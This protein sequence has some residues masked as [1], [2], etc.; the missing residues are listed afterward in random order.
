MDSLF[1]SI[2]TCAA[3]ASP[4]E[5]TPQRLL[6]TEVPCRWIVK[7][8]CIK[9]VPL[10]GQVWLGTVGGM[11]AARY[12]R[13]IR[14]SAAPAPLATVLALLIIMLPS[15]AVRSA[16]PS[17]ESEEVASK[18]RRDCSHLSGRQLSDCNCRDALERTEEAWERGDVVAAG[19]L[20]LDCDV[21][22]PGLVSREK[23]LLQAVRSAT[24]PLDT[25]ARPMRVLTTEHRAATQGR[26][27]AREPRA[28]QG[29]GRTEQGGHP[30]VP[31][32]LPG[33]RGAG[34]AV[35]AQLHDAGRPRALPPLG[36]GR[37]RGPRREPPNRPRGPPILG[38]L[39]A[40]PEM[41][42][43]VQVS[44]GHNAQLATLAGACPP[45]P[46]PRAD[47]G[48]LTQPKNFAVRDATLYIAAVFLVSAAVVHRCGTKRPGAELGWCP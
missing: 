25:C 37:P 21:T 45:R 24:L 15:V 28:G 22:S 23:S 36:A 29:R 30:R 8:C 26:G 44:D 42:G 2:S 12:V 46:P 32:A 20:S 19:R 27:E 48:A 6:R 1:N 11:L 38:L 39:W 3:K 35:G 33:S 4:D 18:S 47:P 9:A 14:P 5:E 34:H 7:V 40:A 41:P 43:A 31:G 10:T 16:S 13:S 17:H